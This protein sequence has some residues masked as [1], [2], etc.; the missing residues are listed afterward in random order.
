VTTP[1]RLAGASARSVHAGG[2]TTCAVDLDAHLACSGANSFGQAATPRGPLGGLERAD[3]RSDW[4]AIFAHTSH[5]C[6]T[7]ADGMLRCWGTGSRGELGDNMY[8]DRQDPAEVGV[9]FADVAV[10]ETATAALRGTEL[11]SW[12]DAFVGGE[13]SPTPAMIA[14]GMRDVALGEFHGC[15]LASGGSLTC[16]GVNV[17]GQLGDGTFDD[18]TA[19]QVAGTWRSVI[20]GS[21]ATC[22]TRT[23]GGLTDRLFCWGLREMVG[24][25]AAENVNVPTPVVLPQLEVAAV[26]LGH[27]FGCALAGGQLWCWGDNYFGQLGT[28]TGMSSAEPVRIGLRT[29]WTAISTGGG[30]ACAIARDRSLWCW[31]SGEHGQLGPPIALRRPPTQ[32]GADRTWAAVAAGDRFTCAIATDGTRWCAGDNT[33]GQLG[34]G[35]SWLTALTPMP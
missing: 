23:D 12:G 31:G 14:P 8:L 27:T 5:A 21:L 15:S 9:G 34:D 13:S 20:A 26:G 24:S 4:R 28:S 35:R 33:R 30:H 3:D 7:T 29:D 19:I 11:W 6:G 17:F 1:M 32:L 18:R 10:N 16:G 22:A 25:E 2:D